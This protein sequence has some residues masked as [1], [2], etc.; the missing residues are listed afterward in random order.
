MIVLL[1]PPFFRCAGSHNDRIPMELAYAS[2]YLDEFKHEH[3]IL[4]GDYVGTKSYVP[5]TDLFHNFEY[6]MSAVDGRSSLY[7][8]IFEKVM[9]YHPDL[10]VIAAGDALMPDVDVSHYRI[11]GNFSAMFRRA[12]IKTLGVGKFVVAHPELFG[13]DYDAY[14][15]GPCMFGFVD[16]CL[17]TVSGKTGPQPTMMGGLRCLPMYDHLA[18]PDLDDNYI[19][20]SFGCPYQCDF[21]YRPKIYNGRHALVPPPVFAKDLARRKADKLTIRDGT[22][23]VEPQRI[24]DLTAAIDDVGLL[25][26]KTFACDIR[27]DLITDEMLE[28]LKDFGVDRI[29]MGL[30]TLDDVALQRMHKME[31]ANT[32]MDAMFNVKKAGFELAVYM[33]IGN[34]YAGRDAWLRTIDFLEELKPDGLVIN[35]AAYLDFDDPLA[36][37]DCHWSPVSARRYG[38]DQDILWRLLRMEDELSNPTIEVLK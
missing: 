31:D 17:A 9:Q 11:A 29:K 6:F 25:G 24:R 27:A 2:E 28:A 16:A 35:T 23:A 36:K 21:C 33:I 12:G 19:F 18:Q 20:T 10:V 1:H 13:K 22:I 37:Y 8:E 26:K 15:T 32:I 14:V 34:D 5:W 4:N 3:V 7:S 30:E 38:V